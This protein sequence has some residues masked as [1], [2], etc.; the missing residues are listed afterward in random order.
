VV[1]RTGAW[2]Q[3][4]GEG[5]GSRGTPIFTAVFEFLFDQSR[6]NYFLNLALFPV[7][8]ACWWS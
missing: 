2:G 6:N 8:I 5:E 3:C 4:E 1:V 7:Y